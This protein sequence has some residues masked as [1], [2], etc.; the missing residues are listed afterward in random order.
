MNDYAGL[1]AAGEREKLDAKLA[2]F[3]KQSGAQ[4]YFAIFPT[5][6]S[7]DLEDFSIRLAQ[8][9]KLGKQ[10][11]DNGILVSLFMKER[12]IRI[13]VGYGLEDKIPDVAAGRIIR[14]MAPYFQHND[15][16]GGLN[17]TAEGLIALARGE[18]P[19][20]QPFPDQEPRHVFPWP[21]FLVFVLML[22]SFLRAVIPRRPTSGFRVDRHGRHPN[23]IP[24]W[25]PLV[26]G[27]GGRRGGGRFG[28]DWGGSGGGFGGGGGGRFGGGGAS[29]SW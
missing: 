27:S 28:G 22:S 14:E 20:E 24:W 26:L 4:L 3:E 10:G 2:A 25:L 16:S 9:W 6:G 19:P 1:L 5:L 15:Y 8:Q 18:V 21:L 11:R 29:G 17:Q 13:E 23:S 12:R 7:E